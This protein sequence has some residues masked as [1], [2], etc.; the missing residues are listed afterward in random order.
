M[1]APVM[2]DDGDFKIGRTLADEHYEKSRV[3]VL[4]VGD[5]GSIGAT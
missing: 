4:D 5:P 3:T 2:V 1:A